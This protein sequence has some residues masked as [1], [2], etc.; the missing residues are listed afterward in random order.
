VYCC[1]LLHEFVGERRTQDVAQIMAEIK[2]VLCEQGLL[3]LTVLAGEPE[4][5]LPHV[6]FFTRQMFERATSGLHTIA[7]EMYND[8]GCT[9]R[10]DY[11]IWYGLF[12][13]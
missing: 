8:I 10:P 9:N 5:G 7:I 13:N 4:T 1:G 12:E 3:V 11:H 6:Q 2:R